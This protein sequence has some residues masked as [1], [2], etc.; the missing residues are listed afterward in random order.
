MTKLRIGYFGDGPWASRAL[1][2]LVQRDRNVEVSFVVP[3]YETRDP[4]LI[5][6][7]EN[8][9]IPVKL[10]ANVNERA[11]LDEIQAFKPDLLVSMS[12]NQILKN[13][14]LS[15]TKHGAINCHAGALPAYRGRNVIN[16]ALIN[17]EKEF[18]ITVHY[19]DDRIDT[20]DIIDQVMMPIKKDNYYSDLLELAYKECASILVSSIEKIANGTVN[21]RSQLR[22]GGFYCSQRIEGDEWIDWSWGSQRIYDFV[23]ALSPPGPGAWF[24]IG[25]SVFAAH[26]SE[27]LEDAP[28]KIGI[29]GAVVGRRPDGV[30]VKS[31]DNVI[32]L[33]LCAEA[34]NSETV[35]IPDWPVSTRLTG[36]LDYRLQR[37][38]E[39]A[40][41][42]EGNP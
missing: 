34:R 15:S 4:A 33:T 28:D 1:E 10:Y 40:R 22:S 21:R 39:N 6:I 12:F 18:G 7:A 20:G 8:A 3:R 9:G 36:L 14:I 38:E 24:A 32:L 5:E 13:E 42:L 41:K 31:G 16:W 19:I 35:F 26:R 29:Q 2:Q 37:L 11:A 30:V 23:R 25:D 27:L 17:G